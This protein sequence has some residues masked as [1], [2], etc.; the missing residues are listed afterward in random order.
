MNTASFYGSDTR[1]EWVTR[2]AYRAMLCRRELDTLSARLIAD[3][4]FEASCDLE[5]EAAAEIYATSAS[6]GRFAAGV[7]RQLALDL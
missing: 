3:S 1:L 5:P 4:E 7:P 6:T 2:F